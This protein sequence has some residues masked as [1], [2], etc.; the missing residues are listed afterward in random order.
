MTVRFTPSAAARAADSRIGS[1]SRKWPGCFALIPLDR[2]RRRERVLVQSIT[3]Y[4][5]AQ[6]CSIQP[7][8]RWFEVSAHRW[9]QAA[10]T[11]TLF[12]ELVQNW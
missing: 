12:A 11:D 10:V 9:E 3:A 8:D 1:G 4:A 5:H 7:V 2:C 6:I